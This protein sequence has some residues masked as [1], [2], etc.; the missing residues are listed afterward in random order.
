MDVPGER[1]PVRVR[2]TLR[3]GEARIRV[4]SAEGPPGNQLGP[5]RRVE[6]VRVRRYVPVRADRRPVVPPLAVGHI[7]E[8]IEA[9][10]QRRGP[11]GHVVGRR[12]H[13]VRRVGDCQRDEVRARNGVI[14]T[15][16]R[17]A[18]DLGGR[19]VSPAPGVRRDVVVRVRRRGCVDRDVH[20]DPRGVEENPR[21][22]RR[23]LNPSDPVRH[24]RQ[25]RRSRVPHREGDREVRVREVRMGRSRD[26]EVS[27][28]RPV[29]PRPVVGHDCPPDRAAR[30]AAVHRDRPR[31]VVNRLGESG[32]GR[33]GT[34]GDE[35]VSGYG[36][37]QAVVVVYR[38][39]EDHLYVVVTGR[40]D[41]VRH[42]DGNARGRAVA[43]TPVIGDENSAGIVRGR[44]ARIHPH[45][46]LRSRGIH[47]LNRVVR[48][49][50]D[51]REVLLGSA[52][53]GPMRVGDVQPNRI[54]LFERVHVRVSGRDTRPD[55]SIAKRPGV[56][57]RVS[58][59]IRRRAPVHRDL[60][61]IGCVRSDRE[62]GRRCLVSGQRRAPGQRRRDRVD[63]IDVNR[64]GLPD[65]DILEH[66]DSRPGR[67]GRLGRQGRSGVIR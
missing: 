41:V 8:V 25:G 34:H 19:T 67:E 5:R 22:Q 3:P 20:Q 63:D 52:V 56:R 55:A 65:D 36:S 1:I 43:P 23:L 32:H 48:R 64:A 59:R 18:V 58:V 50:R 46:D 57:Q 61:G 31:V 27:G 11:D 37:R 16:G 21:P 29:S 14:V 6:A 24:T 40:V 30:T 12:I 28:P 26:R 9:I 54:R 49:R 10:V 47:L 39:A 2:I 17:H 33:H 66:I 13:Q 7:E 4:R 35:H 62:A 15:G 60:A 51:E 38:Q 44:V 45:V 53:C 42:V